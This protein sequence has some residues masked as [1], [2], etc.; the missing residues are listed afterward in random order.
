MSVYKDSGQWRYRR[1]VRLPDGTK[2][3]I[4]G[5]PQINSKPE[6]EREEREHIARALDPSAAVP[7][8]RGIAFS[9]FA[10]EWLKIHPPAEN[11]KSTEGFR[12]GHIRLHLIPYFR[13]TVLTDIDNLALMKL[14]VFLK[15]KP[16]Q[17]NTTGERRMKEGGKK[18][19]RCAYAKPQPLGSQTVKHIL[20]TL[21]VIL[22]S[23]VDWGKLE[24]MPKIPE[25]KVRKAEWDWLEPMDSARLLEA[26]QGN[27]DDYALLLFALRTGCRQGEQLAVEWGDVDLKKNQITF[28]R[29]IYKKVESDTK[30]SGERTI[31][32]GVSLRDAL[33]KI[34]HLRGP[35][36]F[37]D[38]A[39]KPFTADRLTS[40]LEYYLKKAGLRRITWHDL[41][42]TFASQLASA[43]APILYIQKALGHT[44]IAT[45]MRYAHLSPSIGAKIVALLDKEPEGNDQEQGTGSERHVPA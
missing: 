26:A 1:M 39:G 28:K 24:K 2:E 19:S 38:Q 15:T 33:G 13:D 11:K 23:A 3:R 18:D 25:V 36:V 4:S 34:R 8:K 5:T 40:R 17:R 37:C 32:L 43:G 20:G 31:D 41:R 44:N 14:V 42:H 30:T 16:T 10:L 45:T 6:A 35:K 27:D 7:K 12:E 29:G 22:S 21:C 9:S